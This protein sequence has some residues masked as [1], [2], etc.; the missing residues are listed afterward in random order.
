MANAWGELTWNAGLWGEQSNAIATLTGFEL[1]TSQGQA[2][3]TPADGWG[4]NN[5]GVLGWGANF[6][7]NSV[8][9]DSLPLTLALSDEIVIGEINSGWGRSQWSSGS[10]GISGTL[11]ATGQQIN[12]SLNSVTTIGEINSG[13]GRFAWGANGWGIDG[14]LA[15][16]G[17]QINLSLNSVT[18]IGEINSGWGRYGWSEGSWGID[19]IN[20]YAT[21]NQINLSTGTL[22]ITANSQLNLTGLQLNFVLGEENVAIATE[23]FATGFT[24]NT[25]LG[26]VDPGPDVVINGQQINVSLGNPLSYNNEGWGRYLWGEEVWGDNG[27]WVTT[28]IIGQQLNISQGNEDIEVSVTVEVS[29][30]AQVGWGVVGWGEQ[31][32]NESEV[33]ITMAISEGTV[34]PSPDA[35]V[36]GIGMT[37]SLAVGTVVIGTGN[38]TLTGEQLNIAQ[39]TAIG[40]ANTIASVTGIGL[41]IAVSTVFAGGNTDV[42]VTGNLLTISLNSVNNQIWTEINTG[43]DATWIEIDTAA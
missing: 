21:G 37:V 11:L 16:S 41:N 15:L 19:G 1:N 13:W 12:L 10:W 38:V 29:S 23:I 17:Q 40:D 42:N 30:I 6:A 33:D 32:W 8:L 20:V 5:W 4:R 36:T 43:T 9:L 7:N 18:T 14:T 39:G 22:S 2:N 35:T 27:T 26:E 24:L 3:Y 25:T 34:D 31:P 28:S